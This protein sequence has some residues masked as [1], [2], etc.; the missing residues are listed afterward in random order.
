MTLPEHFSAL[1]ILCL[2]TTFF[3]L[4]RTGRWDETRG[5]RMLHKGNDSDMSATHMPTKVP[6]LVNVLMCIMSASP[7]GL[8]TS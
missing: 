8:T 6:R 3:L 1:F 7:Y 5:L 2:V 4:T